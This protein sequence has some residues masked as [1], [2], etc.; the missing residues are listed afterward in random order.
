MQAA[1]PEIGAIQRRTL[2]SS[3]IGW[4][5]DGYETSTLILVGTT[6]VS[7]LISSSDPAAVR[8]GLG[9]A[10]S[11]TLVGWA[12][13]GIIGSIVADYVGRRRMLLIAIAGYCVFTAFTAF[14]QSL[15]M[16]IALRFITGLFLGTEWSTGTTLV[17]ETWPPSARAKALGIM[18]SGYGFG[19]FLAALLWLFIQPIAGA[20][21][22]R[23]MFAIGVLPAIALIYI[24]G[25]L[26][27]SKLW[28]DAVAKVEQSA[29]PR[30]F[31][32]LE[33]FQ[34]EV[35]RKYVVASLIMATVTVAVFYAITALVGPF[36]GGLAAKQ[37]LVGQKWASISALVY[38]AGA[39]LGY[40]SAGFLADALGRK[41]YMA[42]T[43][44]AAIASGLLIY[45]MPLDLYIVLAC[46]FVLGCFTLG[47]FSWMPIYLPELFSTAVRSTASG[48]V[49]NA[50]RFVAFPLPY[51][52]AFL[53]VSLGGFQATVLCITL[54]YA[55]SLAT[56][57]LLPETKNKP[58]PA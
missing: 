12:V 8:V 17:A 43:F 18:Q 6:A 15:E 34:D 50:A 38:N 27:E 10:L 28:E 16:L 7:S 57:T 31:T 39:I 26:P 11:S 25:S 52:T 2:F 37:G 53:F 5:F 19:F 21:G 45:F 41:R 24:R 3:F 9:T 14:S 47:V 32:L 22:W 56:L 20:D 51:L 4:M 44:A 46:I 23:W 30:K 29:S 55:I 40:V 36:V 13:G 42:V 49:F 48:F 1:Q 35:E 33:V 54:L 58:L